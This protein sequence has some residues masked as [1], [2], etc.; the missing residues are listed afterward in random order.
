MYSNV[1]FAFVIFTYKMDVYILLL[2]PSDVCMSGADCET[3]LPREVDGC[4][5]CRPRLPLLR[6]PGHLA[7]QPPGSLSALQ[8]IQVSIP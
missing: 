1:L 6:Q 3:R 2:Q 5:N 8:E 7:W 4:G